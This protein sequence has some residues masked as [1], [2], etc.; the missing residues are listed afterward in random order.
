MRK[1]TI[2]TASILALCALHNLKAD[3]FDAPYIEHIAPSPD[4]IL[5]RYGDKLFDKEAPLSAFSGAQYSDESGTTPY[6]LFAPPSYSKDKKYPLVLFLHGAAKRGTNN[7]DQINMVGAR[8]FLLK[9]FQDSDPHF[10]LAPQC[11]GGRQWSNMCNDFGDPL[12][13]QPLGSG[14]C[15]NVGSHWQVGETAEMQRVMKIIAQL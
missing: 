3:E 10:L 13:S 15:W 14:D 2:L 12:S 8:I 11:A 9:E 6:Q 1:Q 7:T 5:D 4:S